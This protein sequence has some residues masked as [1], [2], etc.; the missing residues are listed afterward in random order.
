[1]D[2]TA[3]TKNN[4]LSANQNIQPDGYASLFMKNTGTE[5]VTINDNI[6]IAPGSSFSFDN[7]PY[8]TI[9]ENTSVRFSIDDATPK[10]LVIKT[11]FQEVK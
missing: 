4:V 8:V 6:V 10:L 2:Y 7:L 9:G 1:M 3:T 11:Y 5:N